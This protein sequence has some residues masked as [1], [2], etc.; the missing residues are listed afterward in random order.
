M[1]TL[2][3]NYEAERLQVLLEHNILDT[4]PEPGFDRLASMA[5]EICQTPIAL[6]SLV[7]NKRQWFKARMGLGVS[8]TPR[9]ISLCNHA[10]Q[11]TDIFIVPDTQSDPRFATNPLVTDDPKIRFYAGV[12]LRTP[13]GYALGTLCVIDHEPRQLT[14]L[15]LQSLQAL[16]RQT[17]IELQR[18]R[19][20]TQLT[21]KE[22][23]DEEKE[24]D[25]F[26]KLTA[27]FG[28]AVLSVLVIEAASYWS[29]GRAAERDQ[30]VAHTLEV[31]STI[32]SVDAHL[33]D[34]QLATQEAVITAEDQPLVPR[35]MA[36]NTITPRLQKLRSLTVDNER[37]QQNLRQLEPVLEG[38]LAGLE[39]M[40]AMSLSQN[41]PAIAQLLNLEER[42][43]VRLEIRNLLNQMRQEE[44]Q[45]LEKRLARA[46]VS[47]KIA[48][49]TSLLG[50]VTV[51]GVLVTTY[52]L[53]RREIQRRVRAE[54]EKNQQ[55]DLLSV[56]LSSI[57][58]AVITVD[59]RKQVTFLNPVAEVL[60]GWPEKEARGLHI[61]DIFQ[62]VDIS[63]GELVQSPFEMTLQEGI[64]QGLA[65]NI[66]L[67]NRD[68]LIVPIDDSC[69]P[70]VSKNGLLRGAVMV[71][72]DITERQQAEAETQQA[73]TKERELNELK[74]SFISMISHDIRTPLAIILSSIDLLQAYATKATEEKRQR[75][76]QQIRTAVRRMQDLL[77]DVLLISRAESG[78][79]KYEPT[80][81]DLDEFCRRLVE[82]IQVISG[83]RY[84]IVFTNLGDC[85]YVCMD[86]K[87]MQHIFMNLLSNA[88][89][90][91]PEGGW[92]D[93]EVECREGVGIFRV[94]DQGIGIPADD[95]PSLFTAFRRGR[96]V[97]A[98]SGTGLGLSIVKTCVDM[99]L[100]KI[101]VSSEVGKGT[102]FEVILPL[103]EPSDG[104]C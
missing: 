59:G 54:D 26:K 52:R 68:G 21:T 49:I 85:R 2:N 100:G 87:L 57:G 67:Q 27:R 96:N 23:D 39:K 35:E 94:R 60:T 40:V 63:T 29:D 92:V 104:V 81:L 16:G 55:R 45:L 93:F 7:D 99:H 4:P 95:L 88:V 77:D 64:V 79:V 3:S 75:Y 13:E 44:E 28:I 82:E 72:R 19:A 51:L 101:H 41:P 102:T 103:S 10:I 86:Q 83:D 50:T 98:I 73:L 97:G 17:S 43:S 18:R 25:F 70:I 71:F 89:K 33:S 20:V 48:S 62:I 91:S 8:E 15:Q 12:P 84:D 1:S 80:A 5:K 22:P 6:I 47:H 24:T 78:A 74:S 90:Y 34:L 61:D 42:N 65:D 76:F 69:A 37:Q 14:S 32:E 66:G 58:D 56:T 38:E 11:Q 31:M 46:K 36:A 53:I 9:E 30:W